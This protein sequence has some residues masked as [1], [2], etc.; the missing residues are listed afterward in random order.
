MNLDLRTRHALVCGASQGI[1]QA[2][3]IE[4]AGMGADITLL[5]RSQAG[6]EAVLA[7]LPRP[8]EGQRHGILCADMLATE[9]LAAQAAQLHA[10]HPVQILINNSGGPAPGPL[11]EASPAQ[12]QAAFQQHLCAAQVLLQALLPGMREAGYGRIVNIISTSVK[13]PLPGLGVSNIVRA[14]TAAWAKTLAG[15]L[16][17]DGITVNNVLPGYTQTGRL[18]RLIEGRAEN[19]GLSPQDVA[20]TMLKDVPAGRFGEPAEV[21]ALAAFLCSPAAGYVNGTSIAADGGR[22]RSLN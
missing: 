3:A 13:E 12:L 18:E 11:H 16:A 20:Q 2:I 10:R 4:L 5:A 19:S 6:L 21:A 9:S 17:A 8:A 7:E 1:G 22:V 14:G 15:E